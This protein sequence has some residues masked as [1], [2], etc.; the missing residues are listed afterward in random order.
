MSKG[1]KR[2][3]GVVAAIAVPFAAP[4]IAGALGASTAL[5]GTGFGAFLGT[6]GGS[7]LT[8]AALGGLASAAT[9][10]DPLTGA[11]MGGIGGFA[12]GG[13]FQNLFGQQPLVAGQRAVG[14]GL[15][16]GPGMTAGTPLYQQ[17]FSGAGL[18]PPGAT[19]A[20]TGAGGLSGF[21]QN[22]S[23]G[24][25]ANPAGM[26][27]LAMTVFGRPPQE[28]TEIEKQRLEELKQMAATDRELFEQR[29][30]EARALL[31]KARQEAPKP[32]QAYGA[33]K[34]AAE[35]QLQEATRGLDPEAALREKRKAKIRA[36]Q[37]GATAAAA[38]EERGRKTQTSLVQAGLN[39]LPTAAPEGEA[40]LM[41]PTYEALQQRKNQY[42]SD[43]A[44][45]TG[46]LFGG[47]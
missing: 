38:E 19:T 7:A 5:A 20:A 13:G 9:G 3:L 43:L 42:R 26:A 8:G 14:G 24:F 22:V 32:E 12:G 21:F 40:G 30:M 27:Q 25:L 41:L 16:G 11:L 6:A 36:A 28:L 31:Q 15:F 46:D 45:A 17:G 37:T 33:T 29:V 10:G 18:L 4:A 23:Q 47:I 1:V 39:V 34:I 44:R 35:R 2:V